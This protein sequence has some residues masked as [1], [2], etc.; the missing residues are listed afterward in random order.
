MLDT[1]YIDAVS[2]W[3]LMYELVEVNLYSGSQVPAPLLSP[4]P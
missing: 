3:C 1:V 2:L 4:I